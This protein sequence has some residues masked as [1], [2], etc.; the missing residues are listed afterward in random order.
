LHPAD[1][2]SLPLHH[3]AARSQSGRSARVPAERTAVAPLN[4]AD[5]HLVV[6]FKLFVV[7]SAEIL[8]MFLGVGPVVARTDVPE[9]L[10]H[11]R[12]AFSR[13]LALLFVFVTARL[14]RYAEIDEG[15]D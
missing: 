14:L 9:L 7:N 1:H 3:V 2:T 5:N 12:N 10:V 6:F 13:Q 4:L 11:E 15:R 8:L